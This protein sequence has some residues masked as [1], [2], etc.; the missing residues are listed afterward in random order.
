[1][2]KQLVLAVLIGLSSVMYMIQHDRWFGDYMLNYFTHEFERSLNCRM[3]AQLQD[4]SFVG[5]M[6]LNDMHVMQVNEHDEWSWHADMFCI[7]F[8]WWDLLRY[9]SLDFTIVMDVAQM[10]SL[11]V[12]NRLAIED[13]INLAFNGPQVGMYTFLKEFTCNN[14]RCSIIDQHKNGRFNIAF[15]GKAKKIDNIFRCIIEVFEGALAVQDRVLFANM[16]GS[17]QFDSFGGQPTLDICLKGAASLEI[18]QLGKEM[19]PCYISGSWNHSGGLLSVKNIDHSFAIDPIMIQRKDEGTV[20]SLDAKIPLAYAWRMFTNNNDDNRLSGNCLLQAKMLSQE[21][22]RAIN[23]H[24]V[25]QRIYWQDME[26]GSLGKVSFT[27][28]DEKVNGSLYVQRTSGACIGGDWS[29]SLQAGKVQA[30]IKNNARLT[31]SPKHDWQILPDDLIF[32]ITSDGSSA[33]VIYEATATH[34]K[35]HHQ[36][37]SKGQVQFNQN[38][39]L[40]Q[41]LFDN[42]QYDCKCS[43][44][45]DWSLDHFF[46]N[47]E[48]GA[49]L[50]ELVSS[51]A[52]QRRS[53]SGKMSF[54]S[55]KDICKKWYD[56]DLQGEGVFEIEVEPGASSLV[57]MHLNNG[58]IRLP[59]TYN[60]I[61]GFDCHL[62]LNYQAK[63][64]T[65][66]DLVCNLHNGKI[67]S[68]KMH[69]TLTEDFYPKFLYAP[70][71]VDH[72]LIN[73][74]KEF[75]AVVSGNLLLSKRSDSGPLL[76]G[77]VIIERSQLK[78]NLF[79]DVFQRNFRNY[80]AHSFETNDDELRCDIAVRTKYPVRIQTPFLETDAR[81]DLH[82]RNK[83]RDPEVVG[84]ISLNAGKLYF[85]YKPLYIT[86]GILH[87]LPGRLEDPLIELFA[88]NT[89]K[90]NNITL[91]V[92]GSLQNQHVQLESSPTLTE[93]QIISLLLVGSQEESLNI[94]MPALIMQNI[95]S[96]LF[97]YDQSAVNMSRYFNALFKPFGRIHLVPSFIDQ[98]GRG[99]LRGAIE[100]DLSDRWRMVVQKN[101]SLTEDT[102]FELE[103]LFSDDV[104]ARLTR[105]IRR[106]VIGEVEMRYKFGNS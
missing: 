81:I 57:R 26:L 21:D 11:V 1:M 58:A 73:M 80:T 93:E 32:N 15:D 60:F 101:F 47:R 48:D 40:L 28:K 19:M 86:T 99:G 66:Y 64:C 102:R 68:K 55:V 5:R 14:M 43:Y 98:S 35:V 85:P 42:N 44:Q 39:L 45:S 59:R 105:D 53:Y 72:C 88:K 76:N 52:D 25:L 89:I 38:T 56:Y 82:I 10:Q 70:L 84:T 78:E 31:F 23:G 67:S 49:S 103:Y 75:F 79:S 34:A 12:D 94:V 7:S 41:G 4:L 17:L 8:S 46:Y 54:A 51:D 74:G 2:F 61:N 9:G 63:T 24:L 33:D 16:S 104:S 91:Q 71:L 96:I 69:C 100:I 13:H 22:Q 77:Q 3:S 27:T 6:R 36:I 30:H 50:F 95:K 97:G 87:F 92:T 18:P 62:A 37:S 29:G 90:K 65:I 106:D 20:V 83:V